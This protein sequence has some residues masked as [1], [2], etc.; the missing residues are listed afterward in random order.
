MFFLAILIDPDK[1]GSIIIKL[2]NTKWH[3][4]HTPT[5][6]KGSKDSWCFLDPCFSLIA[7]IALNVRKSWRSQ[8]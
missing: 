2:N 8:K 1:T 5:L 6:H 3:V 4:N 7:T